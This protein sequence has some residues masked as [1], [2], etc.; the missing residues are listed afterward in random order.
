MFAHA[1]LGRVL[2]AERLG[3]V[4]PELMRRTHLQRLAVKGHRLA[5]QR[6]DCSGE[7]LLLGL[8]ADQHRDRQHVDHQVFVGLV[9]DAQRVLAGVVAVGVCGVPLLPQEF[10][11]PQEQPRPQ[12]PPHDVGPLVEQ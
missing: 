7:T 9:Q 11:G 1:V 2:D 5:G 4:L 3:E 8:A 10:A 12:L 6:V